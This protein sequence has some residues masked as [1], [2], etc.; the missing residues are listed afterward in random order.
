MSRY[1]HTAAAGVAEGGQPDDKAPKPELPIFLRRKNAARYVREE[2]G[3]PC[4]PNWLAK[5]AVV[6][7]GPVFRRCGRW[8]VYDRGAL[9]D[10]A[11]SRLSRPMRSTSDAA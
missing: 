2:W 1:D 3:L 6:G 4:Q 9:D 11:R 8:P 7:G 5:L 10:W